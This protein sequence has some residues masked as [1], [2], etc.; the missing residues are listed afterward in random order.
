MAM[1]IALAALPVLTLGGGAALGGPTGAWDGS[2]AELFLV[3][4][5]TPSL[6]AGGAS[7]PLAASVVNRGPADP[8]TNV[9]IAYTVPSGITFGG[10]TVED[11]TC[12][13]DEPGRTVTCTIARLRKDASAALTVTLSAPPGMTGGATPDGRFGDVTSD[14]FSPA[15]GQLLYSNALPDHAGG[16]ETADLSAAWP[17]SDPYAAG[18]PHGL[19]PPPCQPFT[20]RPTGRDYSCAGTTTTMSVV[21]SPSSASCQPSP[22]V[23]CIQTWQLLGTYDATRTGQL[24]WCLATT[25]DGAYLDWGPAYDPAAGVLPA[26]GRYAARG[27]E[28]R[29]T[30]S[31]HSTTWRVTAGRAYRFALRIADRDGSADRGSG[32]GGFSGFGLTAVNGGPDTCT[33]ANIHPNRPANVSVTAESAPTLTVTKALAR[34][35]AAADDQFAVQIKDGGGLLINSTTS[36]TT[37]GE[38]ST[39]DAGTGTTGS[40]PVTAG[41][42]YSL[43]EVGVGSTELDRY[44]GSISCANAATHSPTVLPHGAVDPDHPPTVTPRTDDAITCILTNAVAAR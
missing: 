26:G 11:G 5:V 27:G 24:G 38:G 12:T 37:T 14:Q 32:R 1:V 43:A 6:A 33:W 3:D 7:G 42:T 25:D 16:D 13:Y 19:A 8:A 34:P 18:A 29:R 2:R 31:F 10:A 4:I 39:V 17:P 30:A 35:R 22:M 28:N 40:T 41:Q 9:R 15:G 20:Q 44:H 23:T 21:T 36:S